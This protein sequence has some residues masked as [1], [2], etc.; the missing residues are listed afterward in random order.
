MSIQSRNLY[1]QLE[2]SRL[3]N[4]KVIFGL[5]RIKL[6]LKKLKH[7]EKK[8]NKVIQI[9]GSDGKFSV[10]TS[11]KYFIE[12]N[13]QTVAAHISPSLVSIKE[14][15][16]LGKRYISYNEIKKSLKIIKNLKVP[17]TIYE[18]LTVVFL[19]NASKRR[20][21]YVLQEA[22]ALWA[23]D[24]NNV[25]DNPLAQCVV[26]INKQHLNFVR[27][28]TLN[29][30]I[31]QKVGFLSRNTKIY[32]GKQKKST[33]KKIKFFLKKNPS[34][35]IFS[36][37]WKLV[38]NNNCYFYSDVTNKIKINNRNINSLASYE[39][40]C[41]AIKIALDLGIK[42]KIIIKTIPKIQIVG[43]VQYIKKGSLRKILKKNEKLLIDG[44]HSEKSSE[45]LFKFLKTLKEPIY[46]IWG[47]QKN[48]IPHKF[49]KSFRNIFKKIITVT[50][51]NND[52]ALDA[53]TLRLICIKNGYPSETA[54]SIKKAIIK[55]SSK[56]RKTIV[57]FGSLYLVGEFL[58]KN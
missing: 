56:E 30:I 55:I 7:P 19:L 53:N 51:P 15:F 21:D 9:I 11:L 14:R 1:K 47:M 4:K 43:R 54:S 49:I 37:K 39:N 32:V 31:R 8:L 20:N 45:N 52:N 35:K 23:K 44:C 5:K 38:K 17:L 22:G 29:E 25:I 13:G 58:N 28:K 33:L 42:K 16:W 34:K 57:L 18:A 50:I 26:N 48:K 36:D 41:M 12:A 10:L 40:L 27:K 46:G 3:F 24:S 2:A 6:V